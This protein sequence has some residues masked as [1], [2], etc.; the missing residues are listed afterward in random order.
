MFINKIFAWLF[1]ENIPLLIIFSATFF[2]L[3]VAVYL[4]Y[5]SN[6]TSVFIALSLIIG[7]SAWLISAVYKV[8]IEYALRPTAV[9]CVYGGTAYVIL[10]IIL[11]VKRKIIE[12][13]AKREQIERSLQFTL[14]E[15]DNSFI[16]ARLN[17]VLKPTKV[18]ESERM[19]I[20]KI[21][22]SYAKAL[23]EKLTDCRLSTADGLKAQSLME[24]IG[25]YA[26]KPTCTTGEL[27][28]LSEAFSTLLKL[29]A[30]YAV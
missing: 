11:G 24:I 20:G 29:S 13:K 26:V 4:S 6:T 3:N 25:E 5:S 2:A 9:L 15:K 23:L 22:F 10:R 30:K 18:K 17:T 1:Y 27:A 8:R 7:G 14:P 12:R 21:E 28:K 19:E 16:R